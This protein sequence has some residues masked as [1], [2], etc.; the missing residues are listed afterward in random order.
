MSTYLDPIVRQRLVRQGSLVRIDGQGRPLD[1]DGAL[2]LGDV[3]LSVLGPIPLPVRVTGNAL[4]AAWY[5]F[6]RHTELAKVDEL[7]AE[8]CQ[9]GGQ[10]WSSLL[11]SS[12]AVSSVLVVGDGLSASSPLVRVYSSCL[13][14]DVFGSKRC[15][16]GPQLAA[17]IDRMAEDPQGGLLV[18][19]AAHEGRGIGL[20]GQGGD[21]TAGG[22]PLISRR[23]HAQA[24]AQGLGKTHPEGDQ[25]QPTAPMTADCLAISIPFAMRTD[26]IDLSVCP[27]CGGRLRVIAGADFWM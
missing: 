10:Q 18:Y 3:A 27:H 9:R 1:P 12:M 13:T 5:A 7:A 21:L 26:A 2:G 20:R 25:H 8:L 17:A 11:A 22:A 15:E 19:M 4:Q 6:V 14:G 24:R 16:C 23:S